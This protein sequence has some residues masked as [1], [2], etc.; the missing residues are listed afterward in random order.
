LQEDNEVGESFVKFQAKLTQ[1]SK[2]RGSLKS[3]NL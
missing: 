3:V 1:H 2:T